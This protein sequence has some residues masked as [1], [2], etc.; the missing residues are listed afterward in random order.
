MEGHRWLYGW[1][2]GSVALGAASLL[3]P[4]YVVE[5]GGDPFELGL[6]GAVAAFIGAPGA[7]VWGRLADRT[8]NRR[9]VVVGS[10]L[11]VAVVLG[12][13]PLLPTIPLVI[14]ANALLWLSFAA[15]GPVLTLLVV[16]D[17]PEGR[18]NTEI[19][20]LN[21]YQ[22][23]GWAGGL[24][25]GIAWSATVGRLFGPVTG[26]R[27]L[28][29]ACAAASA[30]AAVVLLRTMPAP[31]ERQIRRLDRDR[32]ERLLSTGRRGIRGATF[33]F[34]PTRLYWLTR[35]LHPDRMAERFTPT[36]AAY[37]LG[38]VLFFTGFSAFFAP[39]PLYLTGVGFSSDLVFA[40]YL[41]S[42]LGSAAFYTGAGRL[43]GQYDI[44]LLQTGALGLRSVVMPLVAVA[45]AALAAGLAGVLVN[46]VLF[47]LIG[48]SWAVIAVTAGT[49]VTRLAPSSLRGEALGVYTALSTLAGGIG[50]IAG[51][52]L[53]NASGFV[54][55]FGVAGGVIVAGA[56]IVVAL[57]GISE[58]TGA[59]RRAAG[60]E[61]GGATGD[62]AGGRTE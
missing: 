5:L 25:L 54:V 13:T 46:G 57:R 58:R 2:L 60:E 47:V 27:Y 39:L 22:G 62:T 18:W 31:S 4:L 11:A 34:A 42:S 8:R 14:L 17:V 9:S 50:S 3:V 21:R 41:I 6:L 35:S 56:V 44:R 19:A 33:R 52:A 10:L 7:I 12:V 45:G 43:S 55:A 23:Y 15:A 16:A 61:N 40:L 51:G 36:L 32:V 38:V 53:A 59:G 20:G 49:I 28:F 26:Q 29:L 24:L 37:F 1:G 48:I 30:V